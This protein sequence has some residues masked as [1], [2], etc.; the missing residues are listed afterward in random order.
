[1]RGKLI[2]YG[3][4]V[5]CLLCVALIGQT[6]SQQ[7]QGGGQNRQGRRNYDPQQARQRTVEWVMDRLRAAEAQAP[8]IKTQLEKVVALQGD[9]T[10]RGGRFG[11][12]GGQGG[13]RAG[14]QQAR[15]PANAP[16]SELAKARRQLQQVLRPDSAAD[17]D[18]ISENLKGYRTARDK[19]QKQLDQAR[20]DLAKLLNKRQ[21]AQ[22]VV[23]G[24]VK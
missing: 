22:L 1:M 19:Q 10:S 13:G 15:P 3:G 7:R 9:L 21:E 20:K 2:T 18:K 4:M 6:L 24:Y 5:A 12:R 23:M 16:Q 11:R 8:A 17:D 14:G